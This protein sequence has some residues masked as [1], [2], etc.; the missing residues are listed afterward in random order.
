[1]SEIGEALRR[2]LARSDLQ[3]LSVFMTVVERGGFTAAQVALNVSQSTISRQMSSLEQ[4]LGLRL[5]ERG[6]GGYRLREQGRLVYAACQS[7]FAA[8]ERFRSDVGAISGQVIGQLSLAVIENWADDPAS[9]L[10][11]ALAAVKAQGPGLSLDLQCL[12]PDD[13]ER[14][15]LDDRV[16]LGIGVFH[17]QQPGLTYQ[18]LYDDPLELYCARSH[19]L[20]AAE[21]RGPADLEGADYV[22][23]AYLAEEQVAPMTAS[24][25]SS[26]TAHQ[27]EAVAQLILSGRY[28]GYLPVAYARRWCETGTLRSLLPDRLRLWTSLALVRKPR[29]NPLADLFMTGLQTALAARVQAS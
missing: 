26:A 16:A 25:P 6:R 19:P 1:M 29:P 22:R 11:A 23:R 3:L 17:R 2:K 13:I 20:F 12:A 28:I 8:L 18:T 21:L 9:P 5:C 15:V 24:L 4:S 7:L 10:P 14:A 27:M